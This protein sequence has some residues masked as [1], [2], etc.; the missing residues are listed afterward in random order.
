M[1]D[2]V[3]NNKNPE[4]YLKLTEKQIL[5][6]ITE[7]LN[8]IKEDLTEKRMTIEDAKDELKKINEWIQWTKLE[9]EKKK[10]IWNTFDSLINNL[11]ENFEKNNL[12]TE[13]NEVVKLVETIT[14]KSL[15]NLENSIKTSKLHWVENRPHEVQKWIYESGEKIPKL[16][17]AAKKDKN[18]FVRDYIGPALERAYS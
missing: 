11:E 16:I 18:K 1:N 13:F 9:H 10:E 15:A 6:K 7:E 2:K 12:E 5:K 8:P 3:E 4:N 17:A 14:K